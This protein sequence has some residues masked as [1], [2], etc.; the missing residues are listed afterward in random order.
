MIIRRNHVWFAW[1]VCAWGV[2]GS[3]GL[4][5]DNIG[6]ISETADLLKF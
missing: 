6:R 4:Q 1:I 3:A 2:C 5:L